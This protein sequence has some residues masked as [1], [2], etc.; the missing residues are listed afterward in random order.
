VNTSIRIVLIS[1][2]VLAVAI[3]YVV[4]R[5]T[6]LQTGFDQV[7]KGESRAD[8]V[9]RMGSPS[10]ER[11]GCQDAATWLGEPAATAV[12]KK[13]LR[14]EAIVLPKYWTVGFDAEDRAIAKYEYVSP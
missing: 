13:E 8:V 12:C 11:D 9:R 3:A 2:V 10:S 7:T 4:R 1:L 6:V 5:N 14:Y